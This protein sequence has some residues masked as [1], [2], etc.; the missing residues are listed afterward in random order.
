M[1]QRHLDE[2]YARL[3]G[4]EQR[5]SALEQHIAKT[6]QRTQNPYTYYLEL[7]KSTHKTHEP[8]KH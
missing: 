5:I 7:A 6:E 4:A 3:H 2:L 1:D 8:D